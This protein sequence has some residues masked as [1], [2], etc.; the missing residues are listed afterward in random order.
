MD[1]QTKKK[2]RD[3]L[4]LEGSYKDRPTN[5]ELQEYTGISSVAQI[6]SNSQDGNASK[7]PI[8]RM[9][10]QYEQICDLTEDAEEILA[11]NDLT[12]SLKEISEVTGRS[13]NSLNV[14]RYNGKKKK[15]SYGFEF[16]LWQYRLKKV[17]EL[18]Q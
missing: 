4:Y 17:A 7:Y 15:K 14:L 12:P 8:L 18:A 3:I 9:K 2:V 5:K 11:V 6:K 10:W 16:Y 1:K 13:V